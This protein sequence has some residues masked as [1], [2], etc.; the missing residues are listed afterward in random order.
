M[1]FYSYSVGIIIV[2]HDINL[3]HICHFGDV[4][5]YDCSYVHSVGCNDDL[6]M[7]EDGKST[8]IQGL[9]LF[10]N[11]VRVSGKVQV[12]GCQWVFPKF[13]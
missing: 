8:A 9:V 7:I 2:F 12:W 6:G 11:T 5:L 13:D 4:V 3:A 10:L 1:L